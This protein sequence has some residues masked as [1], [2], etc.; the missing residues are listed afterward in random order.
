MS[1]VPTQNAKGS[2]H[3]TI[4]KRMEVTD[5]S[6]MTTMVANNDRNYFKPPEFPIHLGDGKKDTTRKSTTTSCDAY[7]DSSHL[8]MIHQ[9][10][11]I[12]SSSVCVDALEVQLNS[13]LVLCLHFDLTGT[14]A[15]LMYQQSNLRI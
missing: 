12:Q 8:L 6:I 11:R 14:K 9:P 13:V 3:I 2:S 10:L 7:L 1:Y 15:E 4:A 5:H